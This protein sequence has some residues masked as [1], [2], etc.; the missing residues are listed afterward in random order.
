MD[1]HAVSAPQ[2]RGVGEREAFE[3][4]HGRMVGSAGLL[5][6]PLLYVLT[7]EPLFQ[8]LRDGRTSP[9]L[10]RLCFVMA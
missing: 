3:I 1:K 9:S 2:R 5:L 10:C 6:F 7:L 4:V 8:R